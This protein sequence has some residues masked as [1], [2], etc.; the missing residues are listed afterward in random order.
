MYAIVRHDDRDILD[1]L[2]NYGVD[3]SGYVY[4]LFAVLQ[5]HR[6]TCH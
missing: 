6:L 3:I 1:M 4:D 2:I 5:K